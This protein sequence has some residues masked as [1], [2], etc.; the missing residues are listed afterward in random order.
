MQNFKVTAVAAVAL[1]AFA[2]T[3]HAD[4]K[5]T[6]TTKS[7]VGMGGSS[8]TQMIRPGAQRTE[9]QINMGSM[10]MTYTTLLLCKPRQEYRIDDTAKVYTVIPSLA[11]RSA[12]GKGSASAGKSGTGKM[13]MTYA[14][15]SLGQE[16][17]AGRSAAHYKV[18][19]KMESSGCA[20]NSKTNMVTEYWVADIKGASACAFDPASYTPYVPPAGGCKITFQTKGDVAALRKIFSGLVVRMKM[21]MGSVVSTTEIT[22]LSQAKLPDSLFKI[23]A[24]YKKVSEQEFQKIQSQAMAHSMSNG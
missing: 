14:V 5:Y 21:N 23:P 2:S 24:D 8:V 7:S 17:V 18:T 4:L 15:Q 19:T 12:A 9:T 13:V 3:S 10:K 6:Q 1:A 22:S 20:G 16:K 11:A